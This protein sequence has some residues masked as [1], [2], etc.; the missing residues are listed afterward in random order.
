MM[1]GLVVRFD[2]RPGGEEEFVRLTV[3]AEEPDTLLYLC[4]TRPG[5]AQRAD[6]LR[7]VP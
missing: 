3:R 6:V 1:F 5:Y 7:G 4:H 2:L